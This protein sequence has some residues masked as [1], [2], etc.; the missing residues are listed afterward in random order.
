MRL[1]I[2]LIAPLV[3]ACSVAAPGP[4]TQPTNPPTA[5]PTVAPTVAPTAAP[6]ADQGDQPPDGELS[7]DADSVA[8]W[9]GTF[10]WFGTCL[11]T[12]QLPAKSELP[13]LNVDAGAELTLTLADGT[14]FSEWSAVYAAESDVNGTDLDSG[15]TPATSATFP[16]PPQGDWVIRVFVT[17]Y[18]G[19]ASYAWHVSVN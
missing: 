9:L 13:I 18:G 10:C 2:G 5:A 4:T 16:A 17:F 11:D 1:R 12:P 15:D 8:G 19:D 3:V 7:T 6:T 14:E